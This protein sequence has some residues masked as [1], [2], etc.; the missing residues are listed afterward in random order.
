VSCTKKSEEE[1][2]IKIRSSKVVHRDD[3]KNT[4]KVKY[5]LG[6]DV[7]VIVAA[8]IEYP[9]NDEYM[10]PS[11]N[12]EKKYGPPRLRWVVKLHKHYWIWQWAEEENEI[13][14]SRV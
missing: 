11:N 13:E 1:I 5:M 6:F 4:V 9:L 14:K 8:D 10:E 7:I 3:R 12:K 2:R